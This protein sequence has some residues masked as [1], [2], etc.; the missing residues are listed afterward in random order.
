MQF[1]IEQLPGSNKA[2]PPFCRVTICSEGVKDPYDVIPVCI[3]MSMGSISKVYFRQGNTTLESK[4]LV[5]FVNI[6]HIR[7]SQSR[8]GAK[9]THFLL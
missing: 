8:K 1:R 2:R 5:V 4:R 6:H 7:I 3:Q 9:K